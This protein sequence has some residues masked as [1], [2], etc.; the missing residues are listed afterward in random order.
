LSVHVA[1]TALRVEEHIQP[2]AIVIKVTCR[3]GMA[4]MSNFVRGLALDT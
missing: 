3:I 4:V 2:A 1:E